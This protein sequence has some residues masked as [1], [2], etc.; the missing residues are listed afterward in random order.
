MEALAA[1]GKAGGSLSS[2][3]LEDYVGVMGV[4]GGGVRGGGGGRNV[5][6]D[7]DGDGD[8]VVVYMR[9]EAK[10]ANVLGS[11]SVAV[12]AMRGALRGQITRTLSDVAAAAAVGD[13]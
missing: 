2:V 13:A 1:R 10:V 11:R 7:G 12:R 8:D 5:N 4:R 3:M 6:G 9:G